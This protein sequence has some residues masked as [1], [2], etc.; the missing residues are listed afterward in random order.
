MAAWCHLVVCYLD[1]RSVNSKDIDVCVISELGL[2][3]WGLTFNPCGSLG[4]MPIL[5]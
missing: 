3:L 5:G 4:W 1:C 2:F